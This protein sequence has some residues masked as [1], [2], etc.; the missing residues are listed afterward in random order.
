MKEISSVLWDDP[1][2][3]RMAG[4]G[5]L[6]TKYPA[7][8][9]SNNQYATSSYSSSYNPGFLATALDDEKPLLEELGVDF[10]HIK[11]KLTMVVNPLQK[12][13]V[14]MAQD[15]DL[16]GPFFFCI[17]LGCLLLLTGKVHFGYIFGMGMAGCI[18]LFLLLNVMSEKVVD[19][20]YTVS[21]LGYCLCPTIILGGWR[22]LAG[23]GLNILPWWMTFPMGI[24]LIGWSSMCAT[25]IFVDGLG[26]DD[27]R[28]LI[29][30]PVF[31]LYS[32]FAIISIF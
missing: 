10:D 19:F 17:A 25:N 5:F 11:R 7:T 32:M 27:Q 21:T 8:Q 12:V 13:S 31:L 1:E 29:L 30:Y 2:Q 9:S 22:L 23:I 28:Y 18:S 6:D 15:G 14:Q 24:G 16:A 4:D 26:M 3:T 20:Q